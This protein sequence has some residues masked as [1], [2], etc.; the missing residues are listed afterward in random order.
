VS[1]A[2]QKWDDLPHEVRT[3]VQQRTGLILSAETVGGGSNSQIAA[4]LHTETGRV[5]VK[6]LRQ[7]HAQAWTQQ[8]EADIN[9]HVVP[10]AP[11]LLWR[12]ELSG[13]DLLGF[14]H[15]VGRGADY[16]PGSGDQPVIVDT[17]TALG[18]I[19][20]PDVP[21]KEADQRWT[22][23]LDDPDTARRFRGDALLHT[24]WNPSNVLITDTWARIVDWAWP[25]RG[26]AWID[27]A[28]WVVWLTAAGHSPEHAEQWAAKVPAWA[29]APD[30]ALTAFAT[31]QARL[32]QGIADDSTSSWTRRLAHAAEQ[33]AKH[34]GA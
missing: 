23:Y 7:D 10:I 3:A 15:M 33:W 2:R 34:R 8:R 31:A 29:S 1:T 11:R 28:C 25:T 13:W 18:R 17:I 20:C 21:V 24:D 26:A 30:D 9:A 16:G 22:A 27:P 12:L 32:W 4:T 5:F 6:G 19:P 14:E